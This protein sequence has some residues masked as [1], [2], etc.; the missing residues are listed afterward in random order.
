MRGGGEEEVVEVGGREKDGRMV[1]R[2]VNRRRLDAVYWNSDIDYD[3]RLSAV[4]HSTI[5]RA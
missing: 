4:Y 5:V 3:H 2:V 1:A